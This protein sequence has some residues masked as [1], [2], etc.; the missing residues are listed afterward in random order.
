MAQKAPTAAPNIRRPTNSKVSLPSLAPKEA[1]QKLPRCSASGPSCTGSSMPRKV[2]LH[3]SHYQLNVPPPPQGG[4]TSSHPPPAL[5]PWKQKQIRVN[6]PDWKRLDLYLV[7]E[8]AQLSVADCFI[9][10]EWPI[11][12]SSQRNRQ[13]PMADLDMYLQACM[14]HQRARFY[15]EL[16]QLVKRGGDCRPLYH[17]MN[18]YVCFVLFCREKYLNGIWE[19]YREDTENPFLPQNTEVTELVENALHGCFKFDPEGRELDTLKRMDVTM[20]DLIELY[21]KNSGVLRLD[22]E[23]KWPTRSH[24]APPQPLSDDEGLLSKIR[25][26]MNKNSRC[27]MSQLRSLLLLSGWHREPLLILG[28]AGAEHCWHR[29][30]SY[31]PFQPCLQ[32]NNTSSRCALPKCWFGHHRGNTYSDPV[33]HADTS[34][35]LHQEGVTFFRTDQDFIHHIGLLLGC[36]FDV[37]IGSLEQEKTAARMEFDQWMQPIQDP[38]ASLISTR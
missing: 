34:P 10:S 30:H 13:R 36:P 22:Q 29:T 8:E 19:F 26:Y 20:D 15:Q 28:E 18:Q 11:I 21:R 12:N 4:N 5:D 25:E 23:R 35:F 3:F 2:Q 33:H 16:L 7:D 31:G 32:E 17:S 9:S 24:S 37:R 38:S 6:F 14:V 1:P 27:T